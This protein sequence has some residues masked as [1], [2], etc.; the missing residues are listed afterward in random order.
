MNIEGQP[1]LAVAAYGIVVEK[2][3]DIPLRDGACSS[4]TCCG[5]TMHGSFP[6][7][8]NLGP[9]Q[10]DKLW[11]PPEDLEEKPSPLMNWETINPDWWVP[12]GYAAVRIDARGT[13]KSPGQGEP[14][15]F[16]EAIDFYDA[17]EWAA[18]QPWCSGAVGLTGISY[19][20]INQWFVANLQPPSL[21][22][23]IPWEGFADLY[24]DALF[25]GGHSQP[26]H[27]ELVRHPSLPSPDRP[28]LSG[29]S[30]H[31][32]N[33][34]IVEMA[35]QQPRQRR[36]CGLA[37]AVGQDHAAAAHRRQLV[38]DGA[39]SARQYR[40]LHARRLAAQEA[41]HPFRHPRASV[42]YARTGAAISC[43]SSIT[44]S[45]ASTMA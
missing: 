2:D 33:Q 29:Q 37:G 39:A 15:S 22:A 25:H 4:P 41:A 12:R 28:R 19:F 9:Y 35:A 40:S 23:I 45:R 6:A 14:W 30:R 34:H 44:G 17:I 26:V 18:R 7:I 1:T 24:R 27:A 36:L 5:R 43:A 21:K 38:R 11:I 20:A 13:G 3:V 16:Q 10:K 31:V 32:S 42:L 8:L